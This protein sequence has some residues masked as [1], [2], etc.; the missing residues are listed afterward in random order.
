M[1]PASLNSDSTWILLRWLELKTPLQKKPSDLMGR[2]QLEEVGSARSSL[3]AEKMLWDM[4]SIDVL[5]VNDLIVTGAV[6]RTHLAG[7]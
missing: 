4:Q 5:V 6:R 2:C 3:I 1:P 7:F